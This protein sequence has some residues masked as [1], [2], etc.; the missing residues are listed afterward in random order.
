M[1]S[2]VEGRKYCDPSDQHFEIILKKNTMHTLKSNEVDQASSKVSENPDNSKPH[3]FPGT[4]YSVKN[5]KQ[6]GNSNSDNRIQPQNQNNQQQQNMSGQQD[7]H[8]ASTCKL[9]VKSVLEDNV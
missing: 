5:N 9:Q 2:P 1:F 7:L 4:R 3:I 8:E 6:A